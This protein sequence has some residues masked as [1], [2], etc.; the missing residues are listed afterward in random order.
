MKK[1]KLLQAY[2]AEYAKKGFCCRCFAKMPKA[3]QAD[4]DRNFQKWGGNWWMLCPNCH[5]LSLVLD[6]LKVIDIEDR[7]PYLTYSPERRKVAGLM[8]EMSDKIDEQKSLPS[9]GRHPDAETQTKSLSA[10]SDMSCSQN[11]KTAA[12]TL[13]PHAK[14]HKTFGR[15]ATIKL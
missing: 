11:Q 12:T 9:G 6:G 3:K 4:I 2:P 10:Y 1:K 15:V 14:S 13:K 8:V 7:E 5:A